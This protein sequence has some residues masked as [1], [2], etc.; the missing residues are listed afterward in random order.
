MDKRIAQI[1]KVLD[2]LARVEN[3]DNG[4]KEQVYDREL[5]QVRSLDRENI[6]EAVKT[7][8]GSDRRRQ[9]YS[10]FVFAELYDVSGIESLF[11][12]LLRDADSTGRAGI[13][14]T[15]GLRKMHNMVSI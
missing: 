15:I 10:P 4:T 9:K 5:A 7:A 13:I 6:L 12:G 8:I 1:R 3:S 11:V 14:Q 2:A